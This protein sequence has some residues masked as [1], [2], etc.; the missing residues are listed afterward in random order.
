MTGACLAGF[1]ALYFAVDFIEAADELL[2]HNATMPEILRYYTYRVPAAFF[3]IC[4]VAVLV[5]VLITVSLR[6]RA[7]E[8][9][10]MF[11]AGVKPMRAFAPLA[12]GCVLVSALSLGSSE[13]LAPQANRNARE[14][15]RMRIRPGKV[16]AQFS[17]N[18]YWMRGENAFLSAQVIDTG[19]R[20]LNGFRYMEIDRDFRLVRR[21]DANEAVILSDGTWRLRDVR[22]RRFDTGM[23]TMSYQ[24]KSFNF[25]ETIQGFLDGETPPGEMTYERLYGYVRE[26]KA[27]GYDVRRYEVD[28][29]ARLS[30]PLLT[31]IIGIIAIP[32]A[33]RGPRAGGVWRSIG[34]GLLIG[35]FCW[36]GLSASLSLGRKG[37]LHPAVAAWLPDMLFAG[38][39]ILLFRRRLS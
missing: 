33:M 8:F 39:G 3:L 9:T 29:H 19:N 24:E 7:N 36:M 25:P 35:F 11:S 31:V 21:I 16:A 2:R 6:M 26:S 20:V 17:Q 38:I 4:P 12:V 5:G 28:L 23:S 15:A 30:Y 27:K 22:E 34:A 18:R 37:L 10:A 32:I 14:I 1:L 13:I